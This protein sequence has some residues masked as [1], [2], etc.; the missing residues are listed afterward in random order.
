[1]AAKPS[2]SE[3]AVAS[4]ALDSNGVKGGPSSALGSLGFQAGV[5]ASTAAVKG[6]QGRERFRG[7][8]PGP[9]AARPEPPPLPTP[10]ASF[11][12]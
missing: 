3:R 12:L 4:A 1:M 10:I 8:V 7:V 9:E 11:T 5:T 6:R 2:G